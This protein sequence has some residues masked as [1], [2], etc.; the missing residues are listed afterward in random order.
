VLEDT[1]AALFVDYDGAPAHMQPAGKAADI[2]KTEELLR[3]SPPGSYV[4][5]VAHEGR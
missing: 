5:R 3:Q 2:A 4:V 1:D